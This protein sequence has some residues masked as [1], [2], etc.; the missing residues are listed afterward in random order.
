MKGIRGIS[1]LSVSLLAVIRI[2]SFVLNILAVCF[3][4]SG[5]QNYLRCMVDQT[6]KS[7]AN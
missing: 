2:Y 4:F 7:D 6:R 3:S 5:H 1:Q